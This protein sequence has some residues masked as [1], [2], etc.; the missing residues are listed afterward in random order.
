VGEEERG[1]FIGHLKRRRERWV[2]VLLLYTYHYAV[3]VYA[4]EEDLDLV[5]SEVFVAGFAGAAPE[6]VVVYDQDAA[7]G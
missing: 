7:G 4:G 2:A 6:A 1:H 3:A 5:F